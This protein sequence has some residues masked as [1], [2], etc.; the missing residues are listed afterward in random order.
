VPPARIGPA[1]RRLLLGVALLCLAGVAGARDA[2]DDSFRIDRL[3]SGQDYRIVAVNKGA[4]PV[5][6]V[7]RIA[8]RNFRSDRAWP[9]REVVAAHSSKEIA[10]IAAKDGK[11]PYRVSFDYTYSVGDAFAVPDKDFPYWLPFG[12]GTKVRVTQEPNGTLTTHKNAMSRH[13]VD[14][15]VPKGTLVRAARGGIVIAVEDGFVAGRRDPALAEQSNLIS[16]L[17]ADGT[18]AQYAHLAPRGALVRPGERVEA[19]QAL[20]YSGNTGFSS[21]PHLH[22]DVRRTRIGP[23]GRVAQESIPFSFHA[24]A[25]GAKISLRQHMRITVD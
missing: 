12:K 18:F 15:G 25:S 9:A 21:G 13:A 11:K 22:F 19:G 6:A 7:V 17:H 23:D 10:R 14:F 16:I 5:T 20:A 4:A 8:G 2:A 24:R 3:R 1:A